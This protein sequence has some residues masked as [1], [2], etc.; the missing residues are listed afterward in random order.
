MPEA[1]TMVD[2]NT[3]GRIGD[4]PSLLRDRENQRDRREAGG[5]NGRI[6]GLGSCAML[7]L[8]RVQNTCSN[9]HLVWVRENARKRCAVCVFSDASVLFGQISFSTRRTLLADRI[10]E[11]MP[12]SGQHTASPVQAGLRKPVTQSHPR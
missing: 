3:G 11:K 10:V 6:S 9:W 2:S 12:E 5:V 4:Q 8:H 7:C 1:V